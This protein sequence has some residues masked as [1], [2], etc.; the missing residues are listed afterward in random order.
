MWDIPGCFCCRAAINFALSTTP[1]RLSCLRGVSKDDRQC[2]MGHSY[3]L[4][5]CSCSGS[6]ITMSCSPFF[7]LCIPTPNPGTPVNV[8]LPPPFCFQSRSHTG[9]L[10]ALRAGIQERP[11]TP[12]GSL[13]SRRCTN[14]PNTPQISRS[15]PSTMFSQKLLGR[16]TPARTLQLHLRSSLSQNHTQ[17]F[18]NVA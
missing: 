15:N 7:E 9:Y 1:Q 3:V 11:T 14:F 4:K 6:A 10:V 18:Q 5:P 12:H 16:T 17:I 2:L 8:P 13:N